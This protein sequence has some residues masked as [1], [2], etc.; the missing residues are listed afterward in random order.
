MKKT[1]IVASVIVTLFYQKASAQ[2]AG[3]S[4]TTDNIYRSGNVG[5]GTLSAPTVKFEVNNGNTTL[6]SYFQVDPLAA[7]VQMS[8]FNTSVSATNFDLTHKRGTGASVDGGYSAISL[9]Y[10]ASSVLPDTGPNGSTLWLLNDNSNEASLF[11]RNQ[12]STYTQGDMSMLFELNANSA[13]KFA[14]TNLSTFHAT[15][16]R[17]EFDGSE[18]MRVNS[19]GNVGIGTAS[20]GARLHI[21]GNGGV[22]TDLL[23]NGRIVTGDASNAGGMWVNGALNMFVGQSTATSLGFYNN[24][25]WRLTVDNNGKVGIGTT[26]PDALLTVSGQVHAQ[27]VKVTI[28]A[29]GPDY[30]F[31]SDYKLTSLEEIKNYIDQNRHLPEVPSAKEM[32][33]N[34]VQ[35]GEMNM[36]LLKKIEELTLYTIEMN[37]KLLKLTK[38]NETQQKEI[39]KLNCKR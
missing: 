31:A 7:W 3:G 27:E 21:N 36:L 25:T 22:N 8:L 28:A 33:K 18:K 35:L 32:E 17:W 1:L 11:F 24:G 13:S 20:P 38:E 23:V 9:T 14:R 10:D 6:P 5:I 37:K 34:G 30:V 26:S 15:H 29:P 2:W 39:E 12:N 19:Q 4:A 16:F